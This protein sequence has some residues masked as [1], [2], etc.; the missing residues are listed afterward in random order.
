MPYCAYR[1]RFY[2][3]P[4]QVANLNQT[5][6]C[7]RY[8]YNRSL[9]FR[10]DAWYQRQ[11]NISYLQNSAL[12][13][14]WKNEPEHAWLND[15]STVP[16]QQ[17]LRHFQTAY[18]NFFQGRAKSTLKRKDRH[19]SAEY[20]TSAFKWESES[21]KLAIQAEP[22]P[23]RRSRRFTGKL[24]TV[25][26]SSDPAGRCFVSLLVEGTVVWLP[27]VN[28]IFGIDA[29]IKDVV[30][31]SEGVASG[32]PRNAAKYA[33]RL[34]KHQ[35]R[36]VRKQKGSN[37]RRKA[38]L[39]VARVHA[40]IADCRRDF[41]HKLTTVLIRKNQVICVENLA[42]K[43]IVKTPTLAKAINDANWG[44]LVRQLEYKIW[45]R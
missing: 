19:Q 37:I 4:E 36:L 13:T 41:T 8:L 38:K 6:G 3:T 17:S 20:T 15:V 7:V 31:P 16:L 5:F 33:A 39:K 34:A 45:T 35:R 10:Q 14:G 23:I 12:L 43:N 29:G 42:V 1:Y 26:I 11:E 40:K 44:E 30:I 22:L 21:I 18:S 32:N 28:S 2:P 25:T 24:T 27:V 9:H